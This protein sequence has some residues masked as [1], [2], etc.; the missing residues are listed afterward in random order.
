MTSGIDGEMVTTGTG[1]K[2]GVAASFQ[3]AEI[4]RQVKNLPPQIS[5]TWFLKGKGVTYKPR[6]LTFIV[7]S[8]KVYANS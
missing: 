4:S 6:L 5:S 3:L 2:T 7:P 8:R 1:G